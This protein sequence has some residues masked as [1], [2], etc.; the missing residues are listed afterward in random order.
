MMILSHVLNHANRSLMHLVFKLNQGQARGTITG[1]QQ[2]Y[3]SR[4]AL[5]GHESG[6]SYCETQKRR[7]G[8]QRSSNKRHETDIDTPRAALPETRQRILLSQTNAV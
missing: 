5:N 1:L 8:V 7:C 4:L 6:R 2:I 3:G